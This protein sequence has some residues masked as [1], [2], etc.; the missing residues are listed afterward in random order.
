MAYQIVDDIL[1]FTGASA[2][3][4][5][6]A[7]ADMALGMY[8]HKCMFIYICIHGIRYI[9]TYMYLFLYIHIF[10]YAYIYIYVYI[11]IYIYVY[12]YV[13]TYICLYR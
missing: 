7:Q 4:G 5:K 2:T 8:I 12:K 11:Y 10:I 9:Y 6:P 1:D 13:Y 3:L